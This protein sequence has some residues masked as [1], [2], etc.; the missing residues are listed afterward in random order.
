VAWFKH[1]LT[2]EPQCE[3]VFPR[4]ALFEMGGGWV[5]RDAWMATQREFHLAG[6][7]RA[8]VVQTD[9]RLVEGAAPAAGFEYLVH[10]PWR[11][12]PSVGGAFGNPPGPVNRAKA[13]A[14]SDVLTFTSDPLTDD[15]AIAGEVVGLFQLESDSAAFDLACVLSRVTIDGRVYQLA[16]GY[17]R[18]ENHMPGT[19]VRVSLRK[20]CARLAQGERLRLSIA[21]AAFPAY[22]IN[23]GAGRSPTDTTR[24]AAEI[25]TIA[26]RTGASRLLVAC[27]GAAPRDAGAAFA[28][29]RDP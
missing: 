24:A 7:G 17:R 20:T 29:R 18:V 26:L 23:P 19:D 10:D 21:P 27:N 3:A 4:L 16:E 8:S 22:P 25:V 2:D 28:F 6:S 15:I 12:S 11:P 1:W 14:R 5:G 13:D 9:G